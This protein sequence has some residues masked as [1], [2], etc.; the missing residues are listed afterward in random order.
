M[1]DED[2]IEVDANKKEEDEDINDEIYGSNELKKVKEDKIVE[3]STENADDSLDFCLL[4]LPQ[5][6]RH[7]FR[8]DSRHIKLVKK[9]N[10]RT[11][12]AVIVVRLCCDVSKWAA[13]F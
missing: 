5:F 9:C 8:G 3:N 12:A 11:V 6:T 4:P 1:N 2:K 7:G 10:L 13:Y